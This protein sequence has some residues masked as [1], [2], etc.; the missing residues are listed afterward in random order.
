MK[1]SNL[2]DITIRELQRH[3]VKLTDIHNEI[4]GIHAFHPVQEDKYD[5]VCHNIELAI[6]NLK[7]NLT[8]LTT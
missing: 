7:E 2:K 1:R 5:I 6:Q 4:A 8:D 3:I